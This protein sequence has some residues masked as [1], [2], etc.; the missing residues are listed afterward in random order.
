GAIANVSVVAVGRPG[1]GSVVKSN[2]IPLAVTVVA[3]GPPPALYKLFEDEPH[4]LALLNEGGGQAALETADRYS[5]VASMKVTPDQKFRSKLPGL[6]VKIVETPGEGEY[7]FLRFAWKKR[8]GAN[9][10]LQMAANGSFGPAVGDAGPSYRY[11]AGP[12]PNAFKAAA[13]KL[14]DKLPEGW[15]VV[16]RDLFADF[17]AFSLDGLAFTAG[18]GEAALFD[19]IYLGRTAD[20]LKGCPEQVKP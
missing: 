12:S 13:L 10:L 1:P 7:R 2:A 18:D 16:T 20:D 9:I 4:F 14:D 6:G 5:G 17:G 3:G 15:V 19:H 11:E 8:G